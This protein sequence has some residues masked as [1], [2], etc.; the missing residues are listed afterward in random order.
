[1]GKEDKYYFCEDSANKVIT[2]IEKGLVHTKGELA[3]KPFLLEEWQ[4]NLVSKLFGWKVKKTGL[5]K[6]RTL[7][8]EVPRKNGKSTLI[9]GLSLYLLFADGES[10]AEIVAGASERKQ[11][12]IIHQQAKEMILASPILSKHA[13]IFRDSVIF[14]NSF[15][16][17]ISADAGSKHGYNLHACII[18]ELHAQKTRELFDVLTTSTGARRQP[19]TILVTTAGY[20]KNSICGQMHD[21]S[22]KLLSNKIKD[23]TFLPVIYSADKDDDWKDEK[24]WEKANPNLDISVKRDYLKEMVNRAKNSPSFE[25]TFKRLHLNTWTTNESFWIKQEV[26]DSCNLFPVDTKNLKGRKCWAGLDLSSSIDISALVLIFPDD[27][28][29]RFEVLPFFWIPKDNALERSRKDGVDY[30]L[31]IREGLITA[32]DGNVIDY[33]FIKKQI[34][35][36]LTTYQLKNLAYD[37]WGATQLVIDLQDQ[38]C[39]LEPFGQGFASMSN[40]SKSLETMLL[41]KKIN[42]GGNKVLNG[43]IGNTQTTQDPA[44]NIKPDKKKS[45]KGN[46]ID[47]IVALIM[48]IGLY[49]DDNFKG[50]NSDSIYNERDVIIL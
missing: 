30:D 44:G 5:R 27:D 10:G 38:G 13:E 43:M 25:N 48:A 49:L 22:R 3:K 7:Y 16:R 2:F 40:P 4:K 20:D 1:M 28:G 14:K 45:G 39:P 42:H 8:L 18:D 31:W 23:E 35:D 46:K 37:R 15:Y 33:K 32:T 11:A 36:I 9:A 50:R 21:Y 6:Y 19:L 12:G 47:G 29:E 26:W 41:S 34:E 24:T 17:V